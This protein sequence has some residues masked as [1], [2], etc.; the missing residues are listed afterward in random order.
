M[1]PSLERISR[2]TSISGPSSSQASSDAWQHARALCLRYAELYSL[3]LEV[4]LLTQMPSPQSWSSR[5]LYWLGDSLSG[6]EILGQSDSLWIIQALLGDSGQETWAIWPFEDTLRRSLPG[7]T[8]WIET[9]ALSGSAWLAAARRV[10]EQNSGREIPWVLGGHSGV[11]SFCAE[12][13]AGQ[14]DLLAN[15]RRITLREAAKGGL[16]PA[17]LCES[18]TALALTSIRGA[19]GWLAQ[20]MS[21]SAPWMIQAWASEGVGRILEQVFELAGFPRREFR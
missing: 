16:P 8:S 2:I 21:A 3:P 11:E 1:L 20:S 14:P 18:R 10:L 6:S 13:L 9:H 17:V 7:S 12:S 19:A 5:D 4:D 15:V